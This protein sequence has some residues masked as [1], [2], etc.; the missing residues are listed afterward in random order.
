MPGYWRQHIIGLSGIKLAIPC[1]EKKRVFIGCNVLFDTV[2]PELITIG[3]WTSIASGAIIL[4]HYID[5]S[6]AAPGFLFKAGNVIIG[7]GCF[8]GANAIIC[9]PVSI[10]DHSI[11]GAG[12]IVT[13][14]IPPYQIW[15]GNP[16]RCIG[17]RMK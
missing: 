11:V 17:K 9:H 14:D 13:M 3:N 7:N 12:A 5:T 16:A 4:T 15:G 6:K 8:I 2:Y 1:G 10:G